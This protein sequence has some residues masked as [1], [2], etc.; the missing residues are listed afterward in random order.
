MALFGLNA[1]GY[2]LDV[3]VQPGAGLHLALARSLINPPWRGGR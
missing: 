3:A 2:K 1:R